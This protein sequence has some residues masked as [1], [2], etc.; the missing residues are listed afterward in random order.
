MKLNAL[1]ITHGMTDI[2]YFIIDIDTDAQ[3]GRQTETDGQTDGQT[4]SSTD[5]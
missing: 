1:Y 4:D 2:N 3:T 5:C